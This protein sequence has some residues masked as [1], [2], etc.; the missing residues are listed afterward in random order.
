ML[1]NDD[2][3]DVISRK[4]SGH[5]L[6]TFNHEPDQGMHFTRLNMSFMSKHWPRR[7][8]MIPFLELDDIV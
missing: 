2:A 1:D 8:L 4:K 6:A 3:K 7:L 5:L